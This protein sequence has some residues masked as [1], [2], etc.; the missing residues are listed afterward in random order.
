MTQRT[1]WTLLGQLLMCWPSLRLLEQGGGEKTAVKLR[2]G[3]PL[4]QSYF[5]HLAFWDNQ[6]GIK[7][8]VH[9]A[10]QLG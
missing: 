1:S 9:L 2:A 4:L 7:R 6:K 3:G 8:L 5:R 10:V